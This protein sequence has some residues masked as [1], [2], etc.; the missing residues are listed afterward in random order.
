VTSDVDICVQV[1]PYEH[2]KAGYAEHHFGIGGE[3]SGIEPE[4]LITT[5]QELWI[6]SYY[7]FN[8]VQVT[9]AK[10]GKEVWSGTLGEG[11]ARGV[12]PGHGFYRVKASKGVGTMAGANCCG[13]EF[14]PASNQ[15]AVDEALF[16]VVQEIR[17]QRQ[18]R[19]AKKGEKLT[20]GQLNAP[21]SAE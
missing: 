21:L 14:S 5:P 6:F 19:A 15:F 18:D 9:D 20:E 2:Y 1:A 17:E 11:E 13:G 7:P 16:K 10:S 4:F 3:G 12:H 8:E